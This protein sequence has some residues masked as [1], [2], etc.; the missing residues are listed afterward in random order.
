MTLVA[1]LA[2]AGL[3]G[4]GGTLERS[5]QPATTRPWVTALTKEVRY[6]APKSSKIQASDAPSLTPCS[7]ARVAPFPPAQHPRQACL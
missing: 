1:R 7:V 6:S 5:W 4:T 3:R 2:F